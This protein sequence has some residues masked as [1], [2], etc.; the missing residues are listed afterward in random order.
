MYLDG[1]ITTNM[2]LQQE[3]LKLTAS[4]HT[5]KPQNVNILMTFIPTDLTSK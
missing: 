5:Y 4:A 2:I 3:A 1:I